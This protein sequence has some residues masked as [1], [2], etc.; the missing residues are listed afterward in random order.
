MEIKYENGEGIGKGYND[1][2]FGSFV[3]DKDGVKAQYNAVLCDM[4]IKTDER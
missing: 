1:W 3:R 2:T 4:N